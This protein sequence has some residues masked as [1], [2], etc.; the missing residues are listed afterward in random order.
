MRLVDFNANTSA[1]AALEIQT[2]IVAIHGSAGSGKQWRQLSGAMTDRRQVI[3]PDLP[4]YGGAHAAMVPVAAM[5]DAEAAIIVQQISEIGRPVHL[6]GHSYGAAVALKIAMRAPSKLTSLTII[7]PAMFHVLDQGTAGDRKLYQQIT[8][9]AGMVS[10]AIAEGSP[11]AGME[12][13]V[14]FWNGRGAYRNLSPD[15]QGALAAQIGQV[16][17]NFATG[18]AQKWK[19]DACREISCPTMAIMGLE[20]RLVAQRATEMIA[21]SIPDMQLAMIADAGH[22]APFTHSEIVNRLIGGHIA[23]AETSA[24]QF[25]MRKAA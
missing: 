25:P 4:G 13:F 7:E 3:C 19:L 11:G 14:D 20:S 17:A 22:M 5:M 24:T 18:M 15:M 6:V 8:A 21:Q 2:P 12:R 10:A 16:A 1:G 9:V 23:A